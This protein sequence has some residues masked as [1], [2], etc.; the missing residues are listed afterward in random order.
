MNDSAADCS[1]KIKQN[2]ILT[3]S[4]LSIMGKVEGYLFKFDSKFS[5]RVISD[6]YRSIVNE[7]QIDDPDAPSNTTGLRLVKVQKYLGNKLLH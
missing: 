4:E 6:E 5:E 2:F 3:I 1:R 7:Y